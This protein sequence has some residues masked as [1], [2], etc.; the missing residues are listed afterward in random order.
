MSEQTY[1]LFD[2][3][4]QA[5]WSNLRTVLAPTRKFEGNPL[6]IDGK[7]QQAPVPPRAS[8]VAPR[9]RAL[10]FQLPPQVWKQ[11][12]TSWEME[13]VVFTSKGETYR[14]TLSWK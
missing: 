9:Q 12:T 6:T 7:K 4:F 5:E 14:N 13:I 10:V 11:E 3:R 8:V 1:F 2:H